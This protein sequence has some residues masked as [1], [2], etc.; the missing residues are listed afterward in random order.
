ML[1]LILIYF[2]GKAFYTLAREYGRHQWG[3]AIA[4]VAVY[5]FG[6]L[7]LGFVLGIIVGVDE[8][9]SFIGINDFALGIV[10]AGVGGVCTWIF[11]EVL[12]RK[13]ASNPK[14][15]DYEL[16]DDDLT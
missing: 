13:W 8:S 16:L 12:K 4:G 10:G 6:Q 7:L 1:A 3:M 9:G 11:Y 2:I 15:I 14:H 5:F